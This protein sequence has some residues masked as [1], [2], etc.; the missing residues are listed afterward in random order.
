[1]GWRNVSA[2]PYCDLAHFIGGGGFFVGRA[3]LCQDLLVTLKFK[4]PACYEY[5][6]AR[7]Y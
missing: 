3:R 5:N 7:Q 6:R 2:S 4:P 1:M